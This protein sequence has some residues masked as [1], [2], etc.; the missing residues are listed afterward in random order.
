[1]T[2]K[3]FIY[4]FE[5]I[6]LY[7]LYPLSYVLLEIPEVYIRLIQFGGFSIKLVILEWKRPLHENFKN[8]H[9]YLT[10]N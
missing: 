8:S 1:M 3:S 7:H 4:G 9:E 10:V 6:F 5:M 2:M